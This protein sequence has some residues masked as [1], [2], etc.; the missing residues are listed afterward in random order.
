MTEPIELSGSPYK[1]NYNA[2]DVLSN[3]RF[4]QIY[5]DGSVSG[6]L[7]LNTQKMKV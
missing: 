2:D 3:E 4:S 5:D 7:N 1:V 6:Y